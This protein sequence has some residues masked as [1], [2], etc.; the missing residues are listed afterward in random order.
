MPTRAGCPCWLQ[1]SRA[2]GGR[3]C[4]AVAVRGHQTASMV[5]FDWPHGLPVSGT[6]G[7]GRAP[8]LTTPCHTSG[9]ACNDVCWKESV[10]ASV[11]RP[12]LTSCRCSLGGIVASWHHGSVQ[13]GVPDGCL[14]DVCDCLARQ[15]A[16]LHNALASRGSRPLFSARL[17]TTMPST[18]T[19]SSTTATS[20]PSPTAMTAAA[21]SSSAHSCRPCSPHHAS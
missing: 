18:T 11:R 6:P 20:P 15:R 9:R 4:S 21:A 12:G 17:A 2:G 7:Q 10:H 19:T 16:P 13:C 5:V 1:T 14:P 3:C 8:G